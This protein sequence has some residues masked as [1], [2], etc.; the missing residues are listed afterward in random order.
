MKDIFR[1]GGKKALITGG[2][3]GLGL[4]IA[5][6]LALYG[7]DIAMIAR[8][9]IR[10]ARAK[11]RLEKTRRKVWAYSFDLEDVERIPELFEEI[12]E[13]TGGMDILVNNA[14]INIRESVGEIKLE[15]WE[16]I[17]RINLTSILVLSQCFFKDCRTK[18]KGGRIINIS[19][20]A[21]ESAR[22]NIGAYTVAKGGIR[23]LTK[24]MAV[25]WAKYNIN[26]NAIGPGYFATELTGPLQKNKKFDRW[27]KGKTPLGRWGRPEELIGAAVFLASEAS[28]FVTG[29]TIYVEGGWLAKL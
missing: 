18:K 25:E 20:L 14:G 19:S 4:A 6:G 8:D 22:E 23:Q 21:A 24:S 27:V 11:K 29:Q 1:L 17:M 9:K 28:S 12:S 26:V 3:H 2:S 5:E 10:L 7:A 15:N 16:K 13:E